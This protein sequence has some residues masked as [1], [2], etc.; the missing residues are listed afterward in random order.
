MKAE[1]LL[2]KV[3]DFLDNLKYDRKPSGLYDPAKYVLSMGG[4]RIRP[5]LMLLSYGLFNYYVESV[6]MQG[7]GFV[8][9]L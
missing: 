6:L 2:V 5:V 1:E 3:N 4:K 7:C 9:Y 8:T